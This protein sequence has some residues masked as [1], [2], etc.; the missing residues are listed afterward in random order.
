MVVKNVA[1]VG[2]AGYTGIE[3]VRYIL[4]H[5]GFNLVAVTS[6]NDV[7]KPLTSLYPSLI[8]KTDLVFTA[9]NSLEKAADID[10]VFLAVPHT[11]AMAMVPDLLLQGISVFDLSADFRLKDAS[12]YEQWYGVKHSAPRL[13]AKAIYGLPEINR[14]LLVQKQINHATSIHLVENLILIACPGCYPT[15]SVLAIAPA[16]VIDAATDGPVIINALS[17]VSGAG[18]LAKQ[19]THYCTVD[20][21]AKAY[22][23][24]T[25]RHTP[26]IAQVLAWQA[27]KSMEV[28][29][30][31]HLVPMKRGLLATVT[32]QV[33]PKV[34]AA[35]LEN[36]YQRIYGNEPFVQVLPYG[37]MPQTSS[38][39][40]TNNAQVGIMLDEKTH[41]LIASCAIDNLGKGAASQA[42]QCANIVFG[43]EETTGLTMIPK[44][45]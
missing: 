22:N 32:L 33:K 8:G 27:G 41:T 17:G 25:H 5:P 16:L 29:F 3:L 40:M 43:F 24:A 9:H 20:E 14:S 21:N 30:N 10:A 26:E 23:I 38:V 44:V 4:G 13:L 35:A 12:V 1:V 19:E 28:V 6:D 31:P 15:A 7:D 36:V 18:R 2:G 11:A 42:I 34:S 45:V 37:T 39:L